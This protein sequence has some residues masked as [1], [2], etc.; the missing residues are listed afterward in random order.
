MKYLASK[1]FNLIANNL[2]WI[3]CVIG[4]EQAIWMVG[5]A[6]IAYVAFLIISRT[7]KIHQVAIPAVTGIAIDSSLTLSGFY[8]FENTSLIL[9]LW[10]I[11]LWIAF[12]TTL[13]SSLHIFGKNKI[14]A[15]AV[16]CVGIPANY[17]AGERLGAVVFGQTHLMTIVLLCILWAVCLPLLYRVTELS[18]GRAREAT[19]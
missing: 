7:I 4:R 18:L 16:G 3:G 13:T 9:P 10:L 5:P 6:V 1:P 12:S 2:I 11:I 14:V 19:I 17:F 8:Q 15:A